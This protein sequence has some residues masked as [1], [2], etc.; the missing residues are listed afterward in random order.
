MSEQNAKTGMGYSTGPLQRPFR[1][2]GWIETALLWI[3]RISLICLLALIVIQVLS[4]VAFNSPSGEVVAVTETYLM[5]AMV[6][7]ALGYTFATDNHIRMTVVYRLFRGR[8]KALAD[9]LICT[10]SA[11]LWLAIAYAGYEE[12]AFAQKLGYEVSHEIRL[13]LA[14]ALVIVPIGAGALSIRL[15]LEIIEQTLRLIGRHDAGAHP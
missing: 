3:S 11:V 10:V 13:P 7:L 6:F 14:T 9:L 4:R 5:P 8:G 1:W 2:M 12:A 15:I